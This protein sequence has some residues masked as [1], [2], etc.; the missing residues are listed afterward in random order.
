M[1]DFARVEDNGNSKVNLGLFYYILQ[2]LLKGNYFISI[3]CGF[4]EGGVG[5]PFPTLA[6]LH[7]SVLH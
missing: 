2:Y 4:G 1:N 7:L 6:C 5:G 3:V